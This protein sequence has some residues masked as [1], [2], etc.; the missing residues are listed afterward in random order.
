MLFSSV[1]QSPFKKRKC[2]KGVA[3]D[4]AVLLTSPGAWGDAIVTADEMQRGEVSSS[5]PEIP[6]SAANMW[7]LRRQTQLQKGSVKVSSHC[8]LCLLE[9]ENKYLRKYRSRQC[10]WKSV[11]HCQQCLGLNKCICLS[12]IFLALHW[13]TAQT[14]KS[15]VSLQHRGLSCCQNSDHLAHDQKKLRSF[16]YYSKNCLVSLLGLHPRRD[17]VKRNGNC[18]RVPC[19]RLKLKLSFTRK[20]MHYEYAGMQN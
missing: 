11:P 7:I 20:Q 10:V 13:D 8:M 14:T 5:A 6:S 3:D 18:N 9:A 16:F 12:L 17:L 1:S 15:M 4:C 19:L 2:T